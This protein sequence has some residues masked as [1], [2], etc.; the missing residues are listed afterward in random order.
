MSHQKSHVRLRIA[1]VAPLFVR[2]PPDNYG[3]TERVVYALTEG[4]VRRGHKVT[5]FGPGGCM[6]S[7]EFRP[8]SPA[9]L[10][11]ME[12]TDPLAYRAVQVEEVVR[13]SSEFDVIHS[14]VDY[15]PWLAGGRIQAPVITTMHGRL[16]LP[17]WQPLLGHYPDRPLVSISD[18]QRNP[19]SD[20]P[21]NWVG[22]VH[23]G[24]D[25]AQSYELGDG[26]GG[27][28]VFL[29][30]ISPEKD[31]VAA[32]RIAIKA[33]IPLKIAARIDPR[34]QAYF[35]NNVKPLLNHPLV[36]WVGLKTDAGKNELLGG[37]I[38]LL[39]PVAWDE[40]FGLTF[41]EALACGTPVLSRPRGSLPEIVRHGHHGFL[42]DDDDELVQ[43]CHRVGE[44]DRR[45]CRRWAIERFSTE[46]MVLDYE[47]VA[48]SVAGWEHLVA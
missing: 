36:E 37:A 16:D 35:E 21:L 20:L 10:W 5:L 4:L 26:G 8:M 3:G 47:R 41:I 18:A 11:E 12:L 2:I 44:L 17:E 22:T 7:A 25:L 46:R 39:L 45:A 9:P 33:G 6:T 15:L 30:R 1:E 42:S 40:P 29:G 19:V 13:R 43:A 14:H 24:L 28:L 32:I 48:A 34:D 23:H 38:A 31:T 27:Y